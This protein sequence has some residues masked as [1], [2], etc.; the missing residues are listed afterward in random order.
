MSRLPANL[1]HHRA[2][3]DASWGFVRQ[4][5]DF[6]RTDLAR[7]GIG[8]RLADRGLRATRDAAVGATH[9]AREHKALLTGGLVAAA[10]WMLVRPLLARITGGTDPT[11]EETSPLPANGSAT[12]DSETE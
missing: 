6:L 11:S 7:R 1:R 8:R 3:R 10:V 4:D 9:M 2:M 12:P 5:I